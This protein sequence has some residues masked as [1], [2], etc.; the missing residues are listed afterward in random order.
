MIWLIVVAVVF[1]GGGAW[2]VARDWR[3]RG[4]V[5]AVGVAAVAAYWVI[6]KPGMP[7]DPLAGQIA[8]IEEIAKTNPESLNAAQLMALAQ[9]RAHDD[10]KSPMPHWIIGEIMAASGRPNE[11]MLAFEAALRRDPTHLPTIRDLA[12]LRFRTT[13]QVDE[14]TSALYHEWYRQ[15]PNEVRAG[16][17]AGLGDW[18]AGRKDEAR[19][20]WADVEARTPADDPVRAMFTALKRKYGV[21]A[22]PAQPDKPPG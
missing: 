8:H 9:K 11:A 17:L 21:D 22:A 6:G 16:F 14:Y 3:T 1:V 15:E 13:T 10:P 20:I 4:I 18:V 12:D 7:D 2:L 5:A 19:K